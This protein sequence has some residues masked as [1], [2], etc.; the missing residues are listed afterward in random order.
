[1]KIKNGQRYVLS[2]GREE[3]PCEISFSTSTLIKASNFAA[4][5]F[6]LSLEPARSLSDITL[7]QHKSHLIIT[8]YFTLRQCIPLRRTRKQRRILLLLLRITWYMIT[9]KNNINHER[10]H[11]ILVVHILYII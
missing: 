5:T 6:R 11:S 8:C 9:G 7:N 2:Y 1:M 4:K 3:Q 10:E